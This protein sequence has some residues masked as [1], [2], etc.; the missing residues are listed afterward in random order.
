MRVAAI[1]TIAADK[2][3]VNNTGNPSS[4]INFQTFALGR[5]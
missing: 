3:L 1:R 2:G 5:L 4:A